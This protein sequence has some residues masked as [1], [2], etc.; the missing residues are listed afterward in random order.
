MSS[1][2]RGV[3]DRIA[4][5]FVGLALC[6][7]LSAWSWAPAA[8][9]S[10]TGT[11]ALAQEARAQAVRGATVEGITEYT[12]SNGLRVLLFPDA[13]K[14]TITVNIT[15]LVGSRHEGYGEKGMAHLL[16]HLLFKGTPK[17]PN[18]PQE[19]TERG[20]RPNGSTW[21]DRT[22][23]F[24]T[25]PAS[26]DNLAWALDLEADRMVN[27]FVAKKDLD[28]EMTVVRNEFEAGEN[29]PFGVLLE[30]TLSTAFLWHNYGHSTIGA[31]SDIENVPIERLQA[32]YRKHYQPDNA[33]LVVAGKFEE[34]KALSL[35]EE[36]FGAIPRPVREGALVIYPTYT[37]EPTQDGER[38]V[39]LRRVGDVQLVMAAYHVPPGSHADFAAVDILAHVLGDTPSGRL[40]KALVETGKAARIGAFP[41]QLREPGVLVLFAEVRMEQSLE[42]ARDVLV[43]T[44]D[45]VLARP[46]SDEEV[47]RARAALLKDVELTL[48]SSERVGLSL[49]EWASIGDWRLIFLHRDRLRSVT[50][51]DVRRVAAAYLK[52]SNRTLG[53]FI[54][55]AQPDRAEVAAAP[56][57]AALVRD[58]RGDTARAAGE[59]FDPSPANIETRVSRL[60]LPNGFEIALLPK[61]TRGGAVVGRLTLR[62]GSEKALTGRSA[63]ASLAGGMLMRGTRQRTRQ[64][65]S[66]E[67]DRLKARLN[68]AGG[69]TQASASLETTRENLPAVLRLL[70]EVLREPAFDAKEFEELKRER[71]A[72]LENQKSE[73]GARAFRAFSRHLDPWPKGHARYTETIEEEIEATAAATLEQAKAFYDEFYGAGAGGTLAIVGDFDADEIRALAGEIF[74]TWKMPHAFRRIAGRYRDVAPTTLT[75]ETADKANA[76]FVAGMNLELRDDDPDYPALV[77]ANY[78]MGG[79]FLNSR[80]AVRIRQKEGLSYGVGSSLSAHPIDRT[81]Q[82]VAFAIYAPQNLQRLEAAFREEVER[83]VRDGF[84]PEEVEAAKR[85]YLDSRQVSRAQDAQLAGMLAN[86]LYLD[87]TMAWDAELEAKIRALTPEQIAQ[88]V[89]RHIDPAKLTVV[90][91]GDFA[92]VGAGQAPPPAPPR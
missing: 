64:E 60:T 27:S 30:R 2:R 47:E 57:I 16:E 1:M 19:L 35:I 70:G 14:P 48:N 73:P 33:V 90:R 72:S 17:H 43:A 67:L 44:V 91:A 6:L 11:S 42:E 81:G 36:K 89:R 25:F 5:G 7:S 88:A 37:A 10:R 13:S 45:E 66:D 29:S 51:E 28:S 12:L 80:L 79:G 92:K 40:H 26:D 65:L 84:T 39:T 69:V 75:I 61:R 20:A 18:I 55:T 21:F 9:P 87:R 62:L 24:E 71:L 31:R 46:P 15:Y 74:G 77:L 86:A 49:T 83:V 85:G 22:N 59:A 3:P 32:F 76:F 41:F 34:A 53:L 23:Y 52:G 54:P 4:F 38:S 8:A 56:D 82:W 58:Y 50:T 78:M 63:A 68:V